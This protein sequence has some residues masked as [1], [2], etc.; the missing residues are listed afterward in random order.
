MNQGPTP[1]TIYHNPVAPPGIR[2][3]SYAMLAWN[4]LSSSTCKRRRIARR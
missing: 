3:L 2:S 1:V 4:L